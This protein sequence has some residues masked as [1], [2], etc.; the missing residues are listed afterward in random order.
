MKKIDSLNWLYQKKTITNLERCP[1]FDKCNQNL[2]PLDL[3]LYLRAGGKESACRWMRERQAG[4]RKFIDGSGVARKFYTRGASQM[5][6][7]LLKYVPKK[8]MGRLNRVS[9]KRWQELR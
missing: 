5:P 7:S 9:Q 6:D 3:E 1:H 2:C 8:N 4:Y